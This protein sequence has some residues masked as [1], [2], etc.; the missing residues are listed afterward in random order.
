V[1][2]AWHIAF[3]AAH[4]H[5]V[6]ATGNA[7]LGINAHIQRDLPFTLYELHVQGNPI[8]A[9]DH[10]LV[11]DFLA[12]VDA[13]AE[14]AQRFDPTFDD[15]ADPAALFQLIVDW[16]ALAFSNFVRLRDAPTPEARA[17]VATEIEA[18][19]GDVAEN[20]AQ[21][22]AYPPGTDSASRDAYCATHKGEKGK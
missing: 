13:T 3:T 21:S 19:A 18:Y 11:N 8:S 1:P 7:L 14:I 17:A 5:A 16:R 6:F 10:T 12:Q 22:M 4:E 9:E 20:I 2:P 15:N